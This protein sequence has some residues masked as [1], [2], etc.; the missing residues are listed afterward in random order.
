MEITSDIEQLLRTQ[1]GAKGNSFSLWI[2]KSQHTSSKD[3][4]SS[5]RSHIITNL[6]GMKMNFLQIREQKSKNL[7]NNFVKNINPKL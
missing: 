1:H 2:S 4:I 6:Q 5:Q 3:I 7:S